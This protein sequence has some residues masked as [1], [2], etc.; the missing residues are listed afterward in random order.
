MQKNKISR[1]KNIFTLFFLL[2][3][4]VCINGC[5]ND[6]YFGNGT[7]N[8]HVRQYKTGVAIANAK[9]VIT[10]GNP[11]NGV[12]TVPVDTVFTDSDGNA[13]FSGVMDHDYFYYAE[14]YKDNYF[15]THNNQ[16][17]LTDGTANIVMYAYSFV[18]LHVKNV[19]PFDQYDLLEF[20]AGCNP[21]VQGLTIDTTFLFCDNGIKFMGDYNYGYSY[22]VV[23]N[24]ISHNT[25]FSFLPV[26]ND[27]LII[28]INY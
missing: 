12:G 14:A 3:V 10:K 2:V 23:K 20:S 16:A 18:K 17:S 25:I 4:L 9:V 26:P 1:I 15:D 21:F 13:T 19:N 24:N 5:E 8:I 6:K 27:T 7:S 28:E 22:T 11:G